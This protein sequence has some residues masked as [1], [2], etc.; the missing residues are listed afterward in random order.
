M[1]PPADSSILNAQQ[2]PYKKTLTLNEKHWEEV[3]RMDRS[4]KNNKT[5]R[6]RVDLDR[7]T[8]EEIGKGDS[9]EALRFQMG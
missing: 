3:R 2:K 1:I 5:E 9:N 4:Q 6:A 8:R 7:K